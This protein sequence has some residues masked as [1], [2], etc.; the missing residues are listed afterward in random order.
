MYPS[1]NIIFPVHLNPEICNNAHA[2]LSHVENIKL[3]EPQDYVSFVYLMMKSCIILS[4]SG[5]IQEEA[6]SVNK[7]VLLMRDTTER[8]EAVVSGCVKLVGTDT[9]KV[10]NEVRYLLS[11]NFE[12][13]RMCEAPN[14]FG[15]GQASKKILQYLTKN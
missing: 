1:R 12:Y 8:P 15:N 9:Q 4:D 6:A 3:I 10:V 14:P 11:N 5:G 13:K 7:P 2:S